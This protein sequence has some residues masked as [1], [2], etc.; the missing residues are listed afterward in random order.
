MV[1]SDLS[2]RKNPIAGMSWGMAHVHRTLR[3][4]L[5]TQTCPASV[6]PYE[7]QLAILSVHVVSLMEKIQQSMLE[8]HAGRC[9]HIFFIYTF[10]FYFAG[11]SDWTLFQAITLWQR[12]VE[13]R[14]HCHTEQRGRRG[15]N[16][17]TSRLP[18]QFWGGK[19]KSLTNRPG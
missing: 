3:T 7:W 15:V 18:L 4:A 14:S 13:S 19:I 12:P 5:S 1:K 11:D 16:I 9:L 10:C 17:T 6:C 2:K 8:G